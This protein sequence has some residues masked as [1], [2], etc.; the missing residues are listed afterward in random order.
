M[1][2]L[3]SPGAVS[4]STLGIAAKET[5]SS[6]INSIT[7]Q[8]PPRIGAI[9]IQVYVLVAGNYR[10]EAT[11]SP[12]ED[13]IAGNERWFDIFGADQSAHMQKPILSSVTAVRVTRLSGTHEV[14]I[15]GQ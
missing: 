5:I 6:T 2:T 7:W 11:A 8:I 13:L 3:V 15:R 14:C 10:V 1:A 12:Y 4:G 9:T